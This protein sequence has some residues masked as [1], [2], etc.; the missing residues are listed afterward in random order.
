MKGKGTFLGGW[1][2]GGVRQNEDI[3]FSMFC[4]CLPY[5]EQGCTSSV[6]EVDLLNCR[7]GHF[8]LLASIQC[9][10]SLCRLTNMYREA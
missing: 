5:S 4:D 6:I 10:P 7:R 3:D 1:G 2:G 9:K 8:N